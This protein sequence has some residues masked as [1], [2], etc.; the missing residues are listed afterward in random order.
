MEIELLRDLVIIILGIVLTLT[1]IVMAVWLYSVYRKINDILKSAKTSAAKIEALTV[2]TSDELGK[3]LI[4]AVG[5]IQGI[6]C[7]IR[8]IVRI[9]RKGGGNGT[10]R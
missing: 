7:G 1:I 10:G 3:P 6:T 8:E 4:Q 9:F 5:V 2:I